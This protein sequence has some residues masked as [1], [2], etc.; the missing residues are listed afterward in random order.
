MSKRM[1][2]GLLVVV[3]IGWLLAAL[4]A[5]ALPA[6]SV[7]YAPGGERLVLTAGR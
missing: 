6:P 2:A 5:T 1:L 3:V 4:L 7:W